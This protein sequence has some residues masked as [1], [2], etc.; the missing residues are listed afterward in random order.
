MIRSTRKFEKNALYINI[1]III[2]IIIDEY[3]IDNDDKQNSVCHERTLRW[4]G[5]LNE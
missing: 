1:I 5:N 3:I 2:I 4:T